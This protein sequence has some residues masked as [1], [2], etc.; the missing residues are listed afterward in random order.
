MEWWRKTREQQIK[1]QP[2]TNSEPSQHFVRW[3][4]LS[5]RSFGRALLL[6]V[7]LELL[8]CPV[9]QRG[10]LVLLD[11]QCRT[12]AG[13]RALLLS[14]TKLLVATPFLSA[15]LIPRGCMRDLSSQ[16]GIS[17]VGERTH[18]RFR[19]LQHFTPRSFLGVW[20]LQANLAPFG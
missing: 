10:L 15:M 19:A 7:L 4:M 17:L 14:T 20:C 3:S 2:Q 16:A 5:L 6:L 18:Q 13:H 8:L 1:Q 11:A 12:A 9:I